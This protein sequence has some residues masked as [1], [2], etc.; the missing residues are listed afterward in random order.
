MNTTPDEVLLALWLDDELQGEEL[1]KVESWA[2]TQPDQIA[3]REEIRAWRKTMATALPAVEEPPYPDFFNSR[4]TKE[5][6]AMQATPEPSA[7]A[8]RPSF[9]RWLFP[10]TAF[11]GMALAF[12]VG[13]KTHSTGGSNLAKGGDESSSPV[14]YTPEQGVDAQWV[15]GTGAS[16]VIL[17]N[18]VSAIPDSMDFT[19]TAMIQQPKESDSTAGA[20]TPGATKISR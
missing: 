20:G 12:W 17:L 10:A 7:P 3:A 2:L 6:R 13:T 4:I 14:W 19:E 16:T 11:A 5:I 8:A 15:K 9:W 18:G 1:A